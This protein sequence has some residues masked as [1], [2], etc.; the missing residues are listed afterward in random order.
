MTT[1]IVKFNF[2]HPS[3]SDMNES[4]TMSKSTEHSPWPTMFTP[5]TSK[6]S[7]SPDHQSPTDGIDSPS[8]KKLKSNV[9]QGMTHT[10][11]SPTK[12]AETFSFISTI[13]NNNNS[14]DDQQQ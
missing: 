1:I 6:R 11:T 13:N 12:T 8:S 5:G 10:L 4:S 3:T 14:N 7:L 2:N 9:D